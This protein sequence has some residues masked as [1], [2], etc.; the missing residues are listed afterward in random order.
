MHPWSAGFVQNYLGWNKIVAR[1]PQLVLN[2]S[3]RQ[4]DVQQRLLSRS[5]GRSDDN[6][7]TIQKRFRVRSILPGVGVIHYRF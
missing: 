4:H 7:A 3:S 1:D 5:G 6:I 2:I